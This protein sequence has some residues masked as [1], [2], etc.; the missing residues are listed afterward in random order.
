[1]RKRGIQ[2]SD[3][4]IRKESSIRDR[5]WTAAKGRILFLMTT[6]DSLP[7][8]NR[9]PI[10]KAL[11]RLPAKVFAIQ[12]HSALEESRVFDHQKG[13]INMVKHNIPVLILKS[14]RDSV[15]KYVARIYETKGVEVMDVTNEQEKDLF[16]EHLYHMVDPLNTVAIID[17]FVSEAEAARKQRMN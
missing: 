3:W 2:L 9:V 11:N 15:A 16:K 17:K 12:T 8:L 5:I 7:H 6:M 10:E 1:V 14:E 4:L 13:L